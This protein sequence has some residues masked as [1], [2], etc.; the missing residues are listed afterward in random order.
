VD[1][2]PEAPA[3]TTPETPTETPEPEPE[4]V[5]EKLLKVGGKVR[6]KST[7]K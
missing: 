3:D 1:E 5:V 2:E 4:P 7:A 6:V